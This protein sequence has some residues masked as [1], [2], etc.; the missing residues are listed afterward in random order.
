MKVALVPCVAWV[1]QGVP[2]ARPDKVKLAK[3]DIQELIEG[4]R[5]ETSETS[6]NDDEEE[7]KPAEQGSKPQKKGLRGSA[8]NQLPEKDGEDEGEDKYKMADYDKEDDSGA[9]SGMSG[10]ACFASPMEDP[11]LQHGN[12]DES[13]EDEDEKEDYEIKPNDNLLVIGRIVKD[14]FNLEVWVYNHASNDWYTHHDYI[15]DAPPL[16]LET[17][18]YDPGAENPE[19]KGNLVA[20]GTM[21]AVVN[22]WDLDLV[23]AVEPVVTLGDADADSDGSKKKKRKKR[24]GSQQGHS[25]AVLDLAWNKRNEHILASASADHTVILWDLEEAKI[26]TVLTHHNEKVQSIEWHPAEDALLLSGSMDGGVTISDCRST[27]TVAQWSF[28][29]VEVEQVLWNHFNPFYF[30]VA[31]DDGSIRYCDSRKGNETLTTVDAH[32]KAGVTGLAL[33]QSVEGLLTSVG[34][35][36]TVK[37][38]K[39]G[40]QGEIAFVAD[41][42]PK[43]GPL[44]CVRFCPDV[45]TVVAVGGEKGDFVRLVDVAKNETVKTAFDM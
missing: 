17:I 6:D 7:P 22:I 24:D 44:H 41:N 28:E 25:D 34:G 30:L 27:D 32:G 10:I 2:K 8:A 15:L 38:W 39:L 26:S 23:N 20:V 1:K 29:G 33:S 13:D 45:G 35:D 4:A 43:I 18:S 31:G 3:R 40:K 11:L 42:K 37:I 5:A 19:H 36:D 21:N 16:C 9:T 12:A 14:E